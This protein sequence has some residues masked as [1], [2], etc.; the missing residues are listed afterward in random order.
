MIEAQ[1]LRATSHEIYHKKLVTSITIS[2]SSCNFLRGPAQRAW[3]RFVI[4]AYQSFTDIAAVGCRQ[5]ADGLHSCGSTTELRSQRRDKSTIGAELRVFFFPSSFFTGRDKAPRSRRFSPFERFRKT[6]KN[7]P[8]PPPFGTPLSADTF[9]RYSAHTSPRLLN[10]ARFPY[11]QN[12]VTPPVISPFPARFFFHVARTRDRSS[13]ILRSWEARACGWSWLGH[14]PPGTP[15]SFVRSRAR[16]RARGRVTHRAPED[17]SPPMMTDEERQW[18][19]NP[20]K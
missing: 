20:Q 9:T 13:Y 19:Y 16:A 3:D 17:P 10:L 15:K 2:L 8:S 12:G 11:E 5:C 6:T 18:Q 1:R 4:A 14:S 7:P